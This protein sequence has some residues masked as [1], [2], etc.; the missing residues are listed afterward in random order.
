MNVSTRPKTDES[1]ESDELNAEDIDGLADVDLDQLSPEEREEAEA[2]GE[3]IEYWAG[4]DDNIVEAEKD[5][6]VE[7]VVGPDA[8]TDGDD[9]GGFDA[10]VDVDLDGLSPDEQAEAEAIQERIEYWDGRNE[11]IVEAERDALSALVGE[12]VDLEVE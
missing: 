4:A 7:L 1:D 5:A 8:D 3:R 11:T 6:L 2:I 12:D 10:L 9:A